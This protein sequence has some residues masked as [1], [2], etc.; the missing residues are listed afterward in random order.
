VFGHDHVGH[1][2]SEGERVQISSFQEYTDPVISQCQ[3]KK[4]EYPNVPLFI[5][6]HSMGGLITLMAVL[7]EQDSSL[8]DGVVLMG[9]LIQ[10]AP[11]SASSFQKMLAKIASKVW[12]GLKVG[13]LDASNV[14]SDQEMVNTIMADQSN[15]QGMKAL[16]GYV[17]LNT[18]NFIGENYAEMRTPYLLLH[19]EKDKICSV[20]GSKEFH[21]MSGS[22]DKTLEIIPDGYHHLYIEQDIIRKKAISETW[23]WIE[24]R[25]E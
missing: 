5:I 21:K 11:E 15:A 17:L 6:G 16:H 7:K 9:P 19:G 22:Q 2:E 8:F 4:E 25:I 18:L 20:E 24:K 10:I 1:G 13:S 14:T 3:R 23:D 12:P